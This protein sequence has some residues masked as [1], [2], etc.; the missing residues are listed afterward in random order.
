M[1]QC[2]KPRDILSDL[3]LLNVIL[4]GDKPKFKWVKKKIKGGNSTLA[5]SPLLKTANDLNIRPENKPFT[6]NEPVEPKPD[7]VKRCKT[8]NNVSFI[9]P[10]FPIFSFI[11]IYNCVLQKRSLLVIDNRNQWNMLLIK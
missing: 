4:P 9:Y 8:K 10:I 2:K 11:P 3:K 1:S 7:V 5:S 6:I